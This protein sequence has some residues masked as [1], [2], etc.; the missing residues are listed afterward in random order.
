MKVSQIL[1]LIMLICLANAAIYYD[2]YHEE[3][4]SMP[5]E[6]DSEVGDSILDVIAKYGDPIRFSISE[7]QTHNVYE[8]N[9][10]NTMLMLYG[11]G[12]KIIASMR[13]QL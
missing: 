8:Y 4:I 1:I 10:G 13:A 2:F 5:S 7:D 3:P 12:G 9:D 11:R 6:Q